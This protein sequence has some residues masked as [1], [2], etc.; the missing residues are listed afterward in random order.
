MFS[1]RVYMCK[2]FPRIIL[3]HSCRWWSMQSHSHLAEANHSNK[4]LFCMWYNAFC[5]Y[6]TS[7]PVVLPFYQG[8]NTARDLWA[9][10]VE[11]SYA[12]SQKSYFSLKKKISFI[13]ILNKRG[14]RM[15]PCVTP[16]IKLS[17]SLK[18]LF[19]LVHCF[20]SVR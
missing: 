5:E 17:Q 15:K 12:W 10:Q 9:V 7:L 4:N 18:A 1:C 14:L 19:I 11:L 8:D 2:L 20:R 3:H 6:S 13:K 16:A